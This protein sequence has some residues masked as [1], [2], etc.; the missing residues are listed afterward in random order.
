MLTPII[1]SLKDTSQKIVLYGSASRGEDYADSDIDLFI[2][3]K[4]PD[5]A[6]KIILKS[7]LKR[8]IQSIIKT[9]ADVPDFRA[10]QKVFFEEINMGIILWEEGK[11]V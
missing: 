11:N 3:S 2:I 1:E 8:K 5:I 7:K 4:A 10:N 9:P 6:K